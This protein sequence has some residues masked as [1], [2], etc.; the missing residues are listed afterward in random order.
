MS[1][2][3][4]RQRHGVAKNLYE[5]IG[6]IVVGSALVVLAR[7]LLQHRRRTAPAPKPTE[8]AAATSAEHTE[9]TS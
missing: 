8:A 1:N 2:G 3:M 4:Q 6:G 7:G 5:S 9:A